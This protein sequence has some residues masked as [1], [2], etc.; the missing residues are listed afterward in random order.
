MATNITSFPLGGINFQS[1]FGVPNH[2]S[3]KGSIY[4]DLFTAIEYSNKDGLNTWL[5]NFDTN[6]GSDFFLALS[7]GTVNGDTN[8][9]NGLSANTISATTINSGATINGLGFT[10]ENLANKVSS[11]YG[12]GSTTQ[13]PTTS[14]VV[15]YIT[16]NT[17]SNN[18]NNY[19]A[20]TTPLSGNTK[21]IVHDGISFKEVAVSGLTSGGSKQYIRGYYPSWADYTGGIWVTWP[22][23]TSNMLAN[24]PSWNQGTGTVPAW[25]SYNVLVVN[26]ATKLNKLTLAIGQSY[27]S[28]TYELY[29]QSFNMPDGTG[30]GGET[31]IQTLIHENVVTGASGEY[32]NIDNFTIATH[33]LA[34]KTGI[35]IAWRYISGPAYQLLG[36][37]LVFEFE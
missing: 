22:N 36:P 28:K 15:N 7:G 23:N 19:S 32:D 20:A 4:I 2:L 17:L 14:A 10:P 16:G 34:P 31:N 30:V 26:G 3:T 37:Q 13:F 35:R 21:L 6:L 12:T 9:T 24:G 18:V 8:F 5:P 29:V 1:G 33:T 25:D 27:I 11:F